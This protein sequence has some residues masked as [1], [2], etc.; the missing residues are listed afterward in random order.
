MDFLK[1]YPKTQLMSETNGKWKGILV[2]QMRIGRKFVK[3]NGNLQAQPDNFVG[4]M[5][6]GSLLYHHRK[7]HQGKGTSCWR[8]CREKEA[9]HYHIFWGC[10][11]LTPYWQEIKRNLEAIFEVEILFN[12]ESL[13]LGNISVDG[14]NNKDKTL[15][16]I[17]LAASKKVIPKKWLK[18]ESATVEEWIDTINIIYVMKN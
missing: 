13:Y 2:S 5:L 7:K 17:L 3:H 15:L 4:R 10:Q 18:Q 9:N 6:L 1:L 14:W 12:C 8:L 11:K 16:L